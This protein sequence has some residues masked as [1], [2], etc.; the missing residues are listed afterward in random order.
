MVTL[1]AIT[2]NI[3][4]T[5]SQ[6]HRDEKQSNQQCFL[7][8]LSNCKFLSRQ[9]LAFHGGGDDSDSNFLQLIKLQEIDFP[10]L[11]NWMSKK[12]NTYTFPEIQNEMFKLF[13]CEVLPQASSNIQSSSFLTVMVDETMDMSNHEQV[14]VCMR[15][16]SANFEVQEDFIGLSQVDRIDAGTLVAVIKDIFLRMNISLNKLRG[17]CYDGAATMAVLKSGVAKQIQDIEPRAVFTHCYRHSLNSA[18]GDTIKTSKLLTILFN[19]AHALITLNRNVV[20]RATKT[21][22]CMCVCAC[23][24]A[25]AFVCGMCVCVCLCGWVCS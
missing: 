1:P 10:K 21:S 13:C 18:C 6:R 20:A 15:W 5:L 22:V 3:G 8:I 9:G 23:V 12:T 2:C 16:I 11:S 7:K 14:V 4:V 25:R 24:Y 19:I 17:Q